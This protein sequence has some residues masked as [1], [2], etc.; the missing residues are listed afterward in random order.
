MLTGCRIRLR[1]IEATDRDLYRAL[2]TSADVM[3]AIGPPLT[4]T[5]ADAQF[6]RVVRHN[7]AG[8][9]GH[10]A[11]RV[12]S[13]ETATP[14]GLIALFRSPP[15]AE[16]GFMLLPAAQR[17]G[18]GSEAVELLL[19]HAFSAMALEWIEVNSTLELDRLLVPFAFQRM[20]CAAH[21]Q[22]R[23]RVSRDALRGDPILST[24][25]DAG[26]QCRLARPLQTGCRTLR[27]SRALRTRHSSD[28]DDPGEG[29]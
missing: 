27:S 11:W 19:D 28:V 20:P 26:S 18:Y 14:L 1:P 3:K 17:M 10:R 6:D 29:T 15:G 2:Y 16:M 21:D 5:A 22:L 24:D 13:I 23:W 8:V 25:R 12:E 9:P 7:R 4:C